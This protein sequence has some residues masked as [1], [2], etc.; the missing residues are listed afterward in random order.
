M[1]TLSLAIT[2]FFVLDPFGNL[3]VVLGLL[4]HIDPKRH[5]KIVI[6]E[7]IIALLL[8]IIFYALGPWFLNKLEI[9][10]SD[11]Q[12]CG[13]AVLAIIALRMVFPDERLTSNKEDHSEPFIVPM[14]IPL[15]VGPSALAT[16]MIMAAQSAA[17]PLVGLSMMGLAW[18]GTAV[19]LLVGVL[20]G[21]LIP[22][23]L[24]IALE[25]LFGLL[26]AV[27]AVHMIMSGIQ[28]YLVR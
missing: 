14:A 11:L 7:S 19:L 12:I 13:G 4:T 28:T 5:L 16:V 2:L 10:P 23:R 8:M 26:L 17:H 1:H 15:M 3:P 22:S 27:I 9:G 25:R 24:L 20:M 6:R 21:S 18:L